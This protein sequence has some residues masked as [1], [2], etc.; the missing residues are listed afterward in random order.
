MAQVYKELYQFT[1]YIPPMNFTIHHYLLATE[2][3]ILFAT[4][5]TQQAKEV[6][7]K[8]KEILGGRPLKYI[9]VSHFES[10]ECGGLSVYLEEYPDVTV[11]CSSLC[12]R[13]LHGF[14][15]EG[16]IIVAETSK[17]LKDGDISLQFVE[18]PSEV[19]LQDGVICFE[20]N[21]GIFYSSDLMLRYGNG[22]NESI[23]CN[24]QDEVAAID[25]ERIP[26]EEKAVILKEALKKISPSFVAVG[27]GF[28]LKCE[29]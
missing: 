2:P 10:D 28:C 18:Y 17:L 29:K 26:N 1:V 4:G 24:W 6:L 12:A 14:G 7:P 5:T 15:Y 25:A 16:K 22:T 21:S 23:S 3:A 20:Q 9:F 8:I 19:H 27:H 11:L 13:E